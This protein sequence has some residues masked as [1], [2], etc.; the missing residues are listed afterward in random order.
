MANR[1]KRSRSMFKGPSIAGIAGKQVAPSRGMGGV[2]RGDVYKAAVERMNK[3][4][5]HTR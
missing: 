4:R 3:K 5:S 2:D 1:N